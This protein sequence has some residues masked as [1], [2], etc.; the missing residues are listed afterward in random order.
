MEHRWILGRLQQVIAGT[1][2]NLERFLLHE[3]SH[4]LYHFF[5][6]ELCDWYIE[7]IKTDLGSSSAKADGSALI[8]TFVLE[9]SLRL[10]HPFI[11]FLTE[12]LW[13]RLPHQGKSIMFA[14]YPRGRADWI[15]EEAISRMEQLQELITSIRTARA[16]NNIAPSKKLP[17]QLFPRGEA[18]AFL[19]SHQHQLQNLCRLDPIEFSPAQKDKGLRVGGSI[20]AGR[21]FFGTGRSRG[22][23]GGARADW[24]AAA[25]ADPEPGTPPSQTREFCLR[26]ES[27]CSC[28]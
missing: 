23:G 21:V 10:L 8:A 11:P 18:E 16:E 12:E 15:D 5:W 22:S 27:A 4:D 6:H 19:R 25:K 14:P 20:A 13:Q 7:L 1:N 3:A 17:T 2:R 26:S 24:S 9:N 28:R